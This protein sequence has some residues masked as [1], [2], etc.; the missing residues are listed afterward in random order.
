MTDTTISLDFLA[1][2]Q[3][4][5]IDDMRQTRI[6]HRAGLQAVRDDM[7]VLKASFGELTARM[8]VITAM[9]QRLENA[10]RNQQDIN[11]LI[12]DRLSELS[13]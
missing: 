10:S 3:K 6:E 11:M 9:V 1:E 13:K 8:V 2:Q 12:L 4:R 5:I 7:D